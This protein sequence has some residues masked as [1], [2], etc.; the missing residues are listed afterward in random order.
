[1]GGQERIIFD[2][3]PHIR[4]TRALGMMP[5]TKEQARELLM[6]EGLGLTIRDKQGNSP[7][8]YREQR[9]HW[10][11]EEQELLDLMRKYWPDKNSGGLK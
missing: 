7:L 1:M 5:L 11:I 6:A 2:G 8:T 10:W 4:L 9:A 3:V